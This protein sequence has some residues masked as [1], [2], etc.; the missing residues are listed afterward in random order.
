MLRLLTAGFPPAAEFLSIEEHEVGIPRSI[1]AP[2]ATC[3]L[4]CTGSAATIDVPVGMVGVSQIRYRQSESDGALLS[5]SGQNPPASYASENSRKQP[6]RIQPRLAPPPCGAIDSSYEWS[7]NPGQVT[8][9]FSNCGCSACGC[10]PSPQMPGTQ[11]DSGAE[12]E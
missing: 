4:T 3:I 1:L 8:P 2:R 6:L 5:A 9:K 12:H 11:Q 10:S 7:E